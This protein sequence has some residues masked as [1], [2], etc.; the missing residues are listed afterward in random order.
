MIIKL[1]SFSLLALSAI[2]ISI[3]SNVVQ[4][5][6]IDSSLGV[7]F[8]GERPIKVIAETY[9]SSL[10]PQDEQYYSWQAMSNNF[11][12][13]IEEVWNTY[14]GEGVK[15]AIIDN[16]GSYHHEDFWVGSNCHI[17]NRSAYV[18]TEYDSSDHYIDTYI[19]EVG[20]NYEYESRLDPEEPKSEYDCVY[21]GIAVGATAAAS[22]SGYGTVGVAPDAQIVALKTDMDVNSVCEA[23]EYASD[24]GVDVI[25]MSL[26]VQNA[27]QST[28]DYM[29]AYIDY[30][31]EHNVIVVASAGNDNSY[32]LNAPAVCDHVVG[33]G[34]LAKASG[35]QR[36]NYSNYNR[37]KTGPFN[38]D[39]T[40]PGTVYT[41][42]MCKNGISTY[43]EIQGTSFSSPIVAGAAALYK[44]KYPSGNQDTFETKL[45][46]SCDDIGESGWDVYFGYGRLNVC[47]L[48]EDE[49]QP[50]AN[51]TTTKNQE[52][53]DISW[54]D[55]SNW[56]YRTLH[57]YG[58]N[59]YSGYT[60]KDFENYMTF[61]LGNK[62][63]R[64]DYNFEGTTA[65]WAY[66]EEGTRN[67]YLI[68]TGSSG[69]SYVIHLPWWVTNGY[70]QFVNNSNW[71]GEGSYIY[72][73]D[74]HY[75]KDLHSTIT[76]TTVSTPE[77]STPTTYDFKAIYVTRVIY[78]DDL[79][80]TQAT[81]T[82]YKSCIY[83]ILKSPDSYELEGYQAT[84]WYT[85]ANLTDKYS[86]Q[87]IR[88][89][90][91]IYQ[92]LSKMDGAIY[93]EKIDDSDVYIYECYKLA[94]SSTVVE[95]LGGYP[96]TKMEFVEGINFLGF[97]LYRLPF[98]KVSSPN[99]STD[100]LSI[101]AIIEVDASS[102]FNRDL[103]YIYFDYDP[104]DP[105]DE[106]AYTNNSD[107]AI[108]ADLVYD[109][110]LLRKSVE[111][112]GSIK[113]NSFCGVS[114]S[115][116]NEI[117]GRYNDLTNTQKDLFNQTTIW[118]YDP[119]DKTQ[120]ANV[121]VTSVIDLLRNIALGVNTSSMYI[122]NVETSNLYLPIVITS[123]TVL[124][125]CLGLLLYKKK[126]RMH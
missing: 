39:V 126:R 107:A 28:I 86:E 31:Y 29:Q 89:D 26:G 13:N 114:K 78:K 48:L 23:I 91:T 44:Q 79:S 53:T 72:S 1:L 113:E 121:N 59:Y 24:L 103:M 33:V 14:R 18:H 122:S 80:H 55:Q 4:T 15:I 117:V 119:L 84:S 65:G 43:G 58:L 50:E 19:D 32:L 34:A 17:S 10:N 123:I 112:S 12:G 76:G 67:D 22:I 102:L 60:Y 124:V 109:M 42:E 104:D 54:V 7:N 25:N 36:A 90:I 16:S 27:S 8:K 52:S 64:V 81:L 20:T 73:G 11:L 49:E 85:D 57:I 35:T 2:P 61:E 40:A 93:F 105:H 97:G 125:S 108:A 66:N 5:K 87:I 46:E 120:N 21:H 75:K 115:D 45:F 6:K 111:E 70:Y 118:T 96:G 51:P 77:P 88:N 94:G 62:V 68:N 98:H 37:S 110:D 56:L 101:N 92:L 106:G 100:K 47:K 63:N 30:A 71:V 116:A 41:A 99:V 83:D 3:N 82:D 9:V 74:N 38:V 95:P 69:N